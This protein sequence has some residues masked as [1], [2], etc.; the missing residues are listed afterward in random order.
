V[1]REYVAGV[2]G[3]A[4]RPGLKGEL[5]A[6][7]ATSDGVFPAALM[8]A[9]EGEVTVVV[10]EGKYRMVRRVLANCGHPVTALHRTRYGPVVLADLGLAEGGV[11]VVGRAALDWARALLGGVE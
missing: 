8:A 5:A 1:E 4:L 9:S 6:G 10:T 11:G 2:E 7:V 3:D